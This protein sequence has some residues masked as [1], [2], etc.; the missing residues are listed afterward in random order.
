MLR[1]KIIIIVV[2]I[3]M[4]GGNNTNEGMN[5]NLSR[6]KLKAKTKVK[7]FIHTAQMKREHHAEQHRRELSISVGDGIE[8]GSTP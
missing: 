4:G 8:T 6:M 3:I 2:I 7:E 5:D 1:A